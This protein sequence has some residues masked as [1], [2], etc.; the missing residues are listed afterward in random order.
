MKIKTRFYEA[1]KLCSEFLVVT[2][3]VFPLMEMLLIR[4]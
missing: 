4:G 3:R 2:Y 1:E